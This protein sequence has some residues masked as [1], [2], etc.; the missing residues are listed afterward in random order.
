VDI[1][2]SGKQRLFYLE[3]ITLRSFLSTMAAVLNDYDF[4][5]KAMADLL[6]Q[7]FFKKKND[8]GRASVTYPVNIPPVTQIMLLPPAVLFPEVLVI[9][10]SRNY[11]FMV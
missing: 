9:C 5:S 11:T 10:G 4:E 6:F 1:A 3:K 8:C 2:C 7:L